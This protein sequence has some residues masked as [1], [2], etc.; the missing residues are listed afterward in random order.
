MDE[1]LK[2]AGE[3]HRLRGAF[4]TCEMSCAATPKGS[5]LS[6]DSEFVSIAKAGNCFPAVLKIV[7]INE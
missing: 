7:Q 6:K 2:V 4:Q 1:V 3:M 5:L